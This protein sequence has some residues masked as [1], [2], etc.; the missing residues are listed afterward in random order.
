MSNILEIKTDQD[1]LIF[2]NDMLKKYKLYKEEKDRNKKI[3]KKLKR[4]IEKLEK[5]LNIY[6]MD[7]QYSKNLKSKEN[8]INQKEQLL[9][10]K[11]NLLNTTLVLLMETLK[12]NNKNSYLRRAIQDI[13]YQEFDPLDTKRLTRSK[14]SP[15]TLGELALTN[16]IIRLKNIAIK[17]HLAIGQQRRFLRIMEKV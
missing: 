17:K 10:I 1:Y 14:S 16:R 4:K 12:N 9:N 3:I 5:K 2:C 8:T 6:K 7:Y 13:L 15:K 11:D